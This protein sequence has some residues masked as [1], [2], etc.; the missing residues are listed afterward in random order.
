[1]P[2]ETV[3]VVAA[4]VGIFT[5][6]GGVLAWATSIAGP[7]FPGYHNTARSTPSSARPVALAH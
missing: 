7:A 2:A 5:L 1:M 3:I 6:F 4:I